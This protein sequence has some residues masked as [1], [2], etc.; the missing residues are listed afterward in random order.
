MINNHIGN[1]TDLAVSSLTEER[2][3]NK[4]LK[5][6]HDYVNKEYDFYF[7][8]HLRSNK[9]FA[10]FFFSHDKI[11]FLFYLK[12]SIKPIIEHNCKKMFLKNV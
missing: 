12:T 5:L 8:F 7:F 6:Y 11:I 1:T 10:L 3:R 4:T 9:I 2:W